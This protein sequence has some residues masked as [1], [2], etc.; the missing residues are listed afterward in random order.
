MSLKPTTW[1]SSLVDGVLAHGPNLVS[2][3]VY[4]IRN[5]CHDSCKNADNS[6]RPMGTDILIRL[7]RSSAE[8]TSDD[9]PLE[10][11]ES[12]SRGCILQVH[13]D[14]VH[15]SRSKNTTRAYPKT[16]EA[17][18]GD[19][20]LMSRPKSGSCGSLIRLWK[21]SAECYLR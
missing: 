11:H 12:Q 16:P 7:D 21:S 5:R 2:I 18:I 8:C 15:V 17:T 9:I 14:D 13:E 10:S 6:H 19:Q 4:R 20:I 1:V 3:F